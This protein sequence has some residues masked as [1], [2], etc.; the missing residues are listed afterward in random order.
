MA[1][2][3]GRI[4][5]TDDVGRGVIVWCEEAVA[6]VRGRPG[7]YSRVVRHVREGTDIKSFVVDAVDHDI[8]NMAV[9]SNVRGRQKS[10]QDGRLKI[11]NEREERY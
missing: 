5:V 7:G 2:R 11:H 6:G 9:G 3:I 8:G 10:C 1:L 4:L